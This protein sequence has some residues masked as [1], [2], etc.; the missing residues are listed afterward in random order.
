MTEIGLGLHYAIGPQSTVNL[1]WLYHH[2]SNADI[3][4]RNPGLNSSLCLIGVSCLY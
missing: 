3:S 2:F 4:P 1:D